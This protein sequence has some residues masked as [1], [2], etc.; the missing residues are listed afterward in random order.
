MTTARAPACRECPGSHEQYLLL[1]KSMVT[2]L[3]RRVPDRKN[4]LGHGI[5]A[6]LEKKWTA[7]LGDLS[8]GKMTSPHYGTE[9][10]G[11]ICMGER[12]GTVISKQAVPWFGYHPPNSGWLISGWLVGPQRG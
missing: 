8:A 5:R 6:C 7:P 9:E 3:L 1:F 2:H 11:V 4:T 12:N 10:G